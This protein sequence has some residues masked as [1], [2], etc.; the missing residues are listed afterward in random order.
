MVKLDV[1]RIRKL[2]RDKAKTIQELAWGMGVSPDLVK[3]LLDREVVSVYY[4]KS[5]CSVLGVSIIEIT[6]A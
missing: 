1:S 4:A 5:M 2:M 6:M 3:R